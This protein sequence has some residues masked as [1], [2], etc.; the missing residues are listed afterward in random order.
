MHAIG[1]DAEQ[2]ARVAEAMKA[3]GLRHQHG[4]R[5]RLKPGP[6]WEEAWDGPSPVAFKKK[7]GPVSRALCDGR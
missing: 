5:E 2:A 3:T 7:K 6:T 4:H 1:S